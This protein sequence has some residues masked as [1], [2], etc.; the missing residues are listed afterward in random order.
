MI[1]AKRAGEV[2]SREELFA[3]L[4]P[5]MVVGDEAL[6][7]AITKL[8]RAFGDDARSYIET[9][10]KRGYRLTAGVAPEETVAADAPPSIPPR[11][12]RARRWPAFAVAFIALLGAGAYLLVVSGRP[13]PPATLDA[14]DERLSSF[15]TVTV[16]PFDSLDADP[17]QAYFARGVSD[18]LMTELGRLSTVRLVMASSA[19]PTQAARRARYLV[20]G[21]LQRASGMVRVNIRVVDTRT[22]EQVWSE[23]FEKPA[24]ELFAL[25]DEIIS[26]LA[27]ALPTKAS[28][29]ARQRLAK[30]HTRSLE[31]YDHFLRAQALFMA[32][33]PREN[34][35][36]R[37][38][39]RRA[40]EID[41]QFARAYAG[42][43]MTHAIDPRLRGG[44]GSAASL[45][46]ALQLAE[47]ARLIDPEIA[48]AQWVL[49][50]VHAQARRHPQAIEALQRVI[51]LNPSFADAYAL[52]G[53]VY[54]YMGEPAKSIPLLRTAMR[55][56]PDAGYLYFLLL[57]RAYFFEN[58]LEQA[59]IN[60]REASLRNPADPEPRVYIV[61]ASM[62]SGNRAEA[63]WEV[64][65]IRSV[66][67]GFSLEQWLESYPLNSP[68]HREKLRKFLATTGL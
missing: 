35:E 48:E 54:T 51:E 10:P 32:R 24:S 14:A 41:P 12:G 63:E 66:E 23:R 13:A 26:K 40:V 58:D 68:P 19:T 59:V 55:L 52:M 25:Q 31:A 27:Q 56:D 16:L 38:L 36:A 42:L 22:N 64:Q 57:G 67:P 39:Y 9:I 20:S 61:A 7:Q 47:S 33:G 62:A 44:A 65:E 6:S 4:W 15:I 3:A 21:N 60:L 17:G 46:R 45:E 34:E 2:V 49:G 53:G 29:S 5:G 43:A 28:E 50:Y 18:G 8:R 11:T 30:R 37:A 1:L